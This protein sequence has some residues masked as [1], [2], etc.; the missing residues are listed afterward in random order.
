MKN[1]LS[2]KV[3]VPFNGLGG[4]LKKN[5]LVALQNNLEGKCST[6]GYIK[7]NSIQVI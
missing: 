7:N 4:N 5:L 6:E 3:L 2:R 1:I